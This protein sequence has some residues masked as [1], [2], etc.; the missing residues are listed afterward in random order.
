MQL[1]KYVRSVLIKKME[2][3]DNLIP[4]TDEHHINMADNTNAS[5]VIHGEHD[6][7]SNIDMAPSTHYDFDTYSSRC[8][9]FGVTSTQRN[10]K[11]RGIRRN[12]V[13]SIRRCANRNRRLAASISI[14]D[15][16]SLRIMVPS[17]A[18]NTNASRLK[19]VDE[20]VRYIRELEEALANK[21]CSEGGLILPE[22]DEF[23][24][25]TNSDLDS[26]STS[27]NST[28]HSLES[29]TEVSSD[30]TKLDKKN[31]SVNIIKV[32]KRSDLRNLV[33]QLI[34]TPQ[35]NY[36]SG[37]NGFIK[38]SISETKANRD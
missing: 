27:S 29:M 17:I 10:R 24:K 21:V 32:D 7:T 14:K 36:G 3:R 4:S 6:R 13:K 15:Y 35:T 1:E 8:N 20:A 19:V 38:T 12:K 23:T 16:N 25:T 9:V 5:R 28:Y 34:I 18:S 11:H 33:K 30:S 37:V 22:F 2:E 31:T 26:F